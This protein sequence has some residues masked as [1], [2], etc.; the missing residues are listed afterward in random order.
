MAEWNDNTKHPKSSINNGQQYTKDDNV[1]L[2]SLNNTI[3]NSFY[4]V[5]VAENAQSATNNAVSYNAQAPLAT[6]QIQAQKNLGIDQTITFAESER[7]KSETDGPILHD[8]ITIS[9]ATL[10]T[11][12]VTAGEVSCVKLG[13]LVVVSF[14]DIKF[15]GT[16]SHQNLYF[17]GLPK[18]AIKAQTFLLHQMNAHGGSSLRCMMQKDSTQIVNWYQDVTLDTN[19]QYYGQFTYVTDEN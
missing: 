15:K 13:K 14:S 16:I 4:A 3:E 6:E 11:D 9:N 10:N 12:V 7:Q 17:S 5:R 19:A 18:K 2:E 1:T 8:K